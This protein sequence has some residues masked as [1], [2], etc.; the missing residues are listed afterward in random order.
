MDIAKQIAVCGALRFEMSWEYIGVGLTVL[1]IGI[2]LIIGIAPLWWPEIPRGFVR[3]TIA[4]GVLAG[5]SGLYLLII[6]LLP[7]FKDRSKW[8]QI[9][10]ILFAL[11]FF[12]CFVW[13]WNDR[14]P[15]P[16]P[17][18][19]LPPMPS[20]LSLFMTDFLNTGSGGGIVLLGNGF[21]DLTFADNTVLRI[22]YHAI[23]DFGNRSKFMVFYIPASP[24]TYEAIDFV[25]GAYRQYLDTI[26]LSESGTEGG[27]SSTKS[28]EL[29]FTGRI[30]VYYEDS[31]TLAQLGKLSETYTKNGS[32]PE[33]RS[34][35]YALTVWSSIRSG[36]AKAPPRYELRGGLPR[37][38]PEQN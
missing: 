25:A 14:P 8:P 13:Y 3:A 18:A 10:M 16:R 12:G 31:L 15:T 7:A 26:P 38:A 21:A 27:Q 23:Q 4:I 20:V 32:S 11:G 6:G 9:G 28:S 22:L 35:A 34:T 36:S 19:S 33:F 30:F 1:A 5:I 24:H 37:L 2:T 17:P 29:I